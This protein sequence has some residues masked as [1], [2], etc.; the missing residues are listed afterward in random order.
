MR[1]LDGIT[2]SMNMSLSKLREL[3]MDRE[4]W[5][6]AVQAGHRVGHNWATELNWRNHLDSTFLYNQAL[7]INKLLGRHYNGLPGYKVTLVA[8]KT[9]LLIQWVFTEPLLLAWHQARYSDTMVFKSN[10]T[11]SRPSQNL[12]SR[13]EKIKDINKSTGCCWSCCQPV[14]IIHQ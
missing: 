10:M 1:W 3:V 8:L 12:V 14:A 9:N 5:C 11:E 2:D 4:A 13:W 7:K 6:A